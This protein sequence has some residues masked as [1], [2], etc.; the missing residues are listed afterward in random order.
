M[1]PYD[2]M[3]Q[4]IQYVYQ[5]EHKDTI[6]DPENARDCPNAP[7]DRAG[8]YYRCSPVASTASHPECVPEEST[9][10]LW[11]GSWT[12][13]EDA[14]IR[15]R[16][17]GGVFCIEYS[18]ET[19]TAP[20]LQERQVELLHALD[21]EDG[22]E[23]ASQ[24]KAPFESLMAELAP[25]VQEPVSYDLSDY[26]Y[27][28]CFCILQATA[29][30]EDTEITPRFRESIPI[31][32]R[33][34]PG[35]YILRSP[36][37]ADLELEKWVTKIYSSSQVRMAPPSP[38]L[39]ERDARLS[40]PRKVL[41]GDKPYFLKRWYRFGNP[42]GARYRELC[43]YRRIEEAIVSGKISPDLRI[44]RL[45]GVVIDRD[46]ETILRSNDDHTKPIPTLGPRLVGV[47]LSFIET[48]KPTWMGT[49]STRVRNGNCSSE[50]LFRWS[51]D[52]D[53]CV[54]ELHNADIVWGD[55]KPENILVDEVDNIWL[56]DFEGGYTKNWVDEDKR[57]TVEGDW[58]GVQR[59]KGFLAEYTK[60]AKMADTG[61]THVSGSGS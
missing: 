47:L 32:D 46:D 11:L 18:P 1:K 59:I 15:V 42:P 37:L 58:Q 54:T 30:A 16:C 21:G 51:R 22:S 23:V 56:I 10:T 13:R 17:F 34:P 55:A 41:A 48:N 3:C 57:E 43:T 27:P 2:I 28:E 36:Q 19:I 20:A 14:E 53:M 5:C 45:R 60:K 25:R 26:L 61:T 31:Q 50:L 7:V 33:T 39:E 4:K 8:K 9:E 6:W 12:T 40:G 29:S 24:L 44:C 35:D 38:S 52:L 49:L